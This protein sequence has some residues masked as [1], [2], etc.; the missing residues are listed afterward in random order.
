MPMTRGFVAMASLSTS[1]A[2]SGCVVSD[3]GTPFRDEVEQTRA[4]S[5][6]GEFSLENTNGSIRV[7]TWDEPRV[8]IEATRAAGSRHALRE[9]EVVVQGEGDRVEV[10]TRSP[11]GFFFGRSGKVDYRVS[12]PRSARVR[13]KNI[14]GRVDVEGVS[15]AVHASNVNG[16][17]ELRDLGGEVEAS[18]TNGS[19]R[20][21][22]SRVDP[23]G[24]SELTTTNGSVRLILPSDAGAEIDARTVN[25][26]IHC[27]FDLEGRSR[28]GRHHLEG[29]IAGGGGRF[30]LRTVNGS[31]H[32]EEGLSQPSA[33]HPPAEAEAPDRPS[34]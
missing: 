7:T 1:L 12:V 23:S 27:D 29:R 26:G 30:E 18:T 21:D 22:L 6:G 11:R 14:N 20:V 10:R 19:L 2:L 34:R 24:T 28:S 13:V 31:V 33:R 8:R 4:L 3:L 9:L 17:V 16:S 5:P 15:G 25:G 32:I